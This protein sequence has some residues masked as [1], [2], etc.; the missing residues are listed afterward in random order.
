MAS[1]WAS[2]F[3]GGLSDSLA[4]QQDEENKSRLAEQQNIDEY[5]RKVALNVQINPIMA[6]QKVLAE[7]QAKKSALADK[8]SA[9]SAQKQVNISNITG[10]ISGGIKSGDF[11][12]GGGMASN[13]SGAMGSP[14][15]PGQAPDPGAAQQTSGPNPAGAAPMSPQGSI[16]SSNLAPPAGT[17]STANAPS[18][19]AP[20]GAP[21]STT[22][23]QGGNASAGAVPVPGPQ[24]INSPE[25]ASVQSPTAN[26]MASSSSGSGMAIGNPVAARAAATGIPGLTMF[27]TDATKL[28]QDNTAKAVMQLTG[29]SDPQTITKYTTAPSP[30]A[31]LNPSDL[32]EYADP[33]TSE[34]AKEGI[35]KR[36]N[37]A[38][39]WNIVHG[40]TTD[41]QPE[42]ASNNPNPGTVLWD[43]TI[44]RPSGTLD[45]QNKF[46]ENADKNASSPNSVQYKD[47][48]ANVQQAQTALQGLGTQQ[49]LN[50]FV[51][52]GP[53][54]GGKQILD[55]ILAGG[56]INTQEAAANDFFSHINGQ[57]A[58]DVFS[59]TKGRVTNQEFTQFVR[60]IPSLSQSQQGRAAI[61]GYMQGQSA[62]QLEVADLKAEYARQNNGL[63]NPSTANALASQYLKDNPI[64]SGKIDP[65]NPSSMFNPAVMSSAN[66][67]AQKS[68]QPLGPDQLRS[69]I[70]ID[71]VLKPVSVQPAS[72]AS[73]A[74]S[75]H[76][77][78]AADFLSQFGIK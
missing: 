3:F 65:T 16:T 1:S 56:D 18:P 28:K 57:Q 30:A 49:Q 59:N 64:F 51:V 53:G 20:Q 60:S 6:Q 21:A 36:S 74:S 27:A 31:V 68:G 19:P 45:A 77:A 7:E 33:K 58:R 11:S 14:A 32:N 73:G 17:P 22:G 48:V 46:Y 23:S 25:N 41:G 37:E 63:Y 67:L 9:D 13:V 5:Y 66:W 38:K 24:G 52:N 75:D 76:S 4:K 50:D 8:S 62:Q 44:R 10:N 70:G 42:P 55:K 39:T 47:T 29:Q 61:I 54:E 43:T 26:N 12:S 40:L 15:Q 35:L 72:S 2:D 78:K 34:T 69:N 71:A